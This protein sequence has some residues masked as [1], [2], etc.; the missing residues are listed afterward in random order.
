[1]SDHRH[2]PSHDQDQPV[3]GQSET[4]PHAYGPG[5]QPVYGTHSEPVTYG[6]PTRRRRQQPEPQYDQQQYDPQQFEQQQQQYG[7]QYQGPPGPQGWQPDPYQPDP[8]QQQGFP[9]GGYPQQQPYGQDAYEEYQPAPFEEQGPRGRRAE[10]GDPDFDEHRWG[11]GDRFDDDDEPR[12]L[13]W[14][15]RKKED[16][17]YDPLPESAAASVA[18]SVATP[19]GAPPAPPQKP[20]AKKGKGDKGGGGKGLGLLGW[21][22]VVLTSLLVL[23]TLTAYTIYSRTRS[24]I[25]F[26][27]S[28]DELDKNR[29]ENQTGAINVLLV[30]SDT[31]AGDNSKYGQKASREDKT[32]RTDTIMLL[33]ITP[34]RDGARLISFPRDAMVQI[35]ECKNADGQIRPSHFAQ[36]NEA[37]NN[38]G[39]LCT[40]RTIET[41]TNIPVD[42]YIKVD[43]TGFKN[44]VDALDGIQICVPQAVVDPKAK[45]NLKAGEQVVKGEAALAYVRARYQLGDGSDIGRIR[46]QQIFISQVVKKA[47][48]SAMLTDPG[49]LLGFVEAASKSV[50]MD[51]RLNTE[52]LIEIA[53]SAGKLTAKGF[54]ATTVPWEPFSGDKNRVQFKQPAANNLFSSIVHDTEVA[55]APSASASAN[56]SAPVDNSPKPTE[57]AQVRVQV[58]NGTDT[59][60]KAKEVA[61]QL[62]AQGFKVTTLG[63]GIGADGVDRPTTTISYKGSGWEGSKLLAASLLNEVKPDTKPI[64]PSA[65][66]KYTPVT[67]PPDADK[68]AVGPVIQ[69]VIGAD[70]KG[71]KIPLAATED[72]ST[73]DSQTDICQ[74]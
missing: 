27:E 24:N 37:F 21:T 52:R 41:L 30:G 17:G 60:G 43:F 56:P 13:R 73:V 63:N 7:Q 10:G 6:H 31:R 33:H 71:V 58:I 9:P 59:A 23:G 19:V 38:G 8:Y 32:E 22:S 72:A 39:M 44:I 47:T 2:R 5:D 14:G 54:K 64:T 28:T 25:D 42:H 51:N 65:P 66:N 61:D 29:P 46:R 36:I 11:V 34:N 35:P 68:K 57:A 4:G 74:T 15:R 1:M 16:D 20:P 70:F 40:R 26:G 48:S 3:W 55:P 12:R 49:R 67:P 69:L 18:T 62:S 53:R 45:L 50:Q